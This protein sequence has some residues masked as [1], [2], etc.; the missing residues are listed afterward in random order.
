MSPQGRILRE[1]N[2]MPDRQTGARRFRRGDKDIPR[3]DARAHPIW[4]KGMRP[5]TSEGQ[6]KRA[7]TS[8]GWAPTGELARRMALFRR[9]ISLADSDDAGKFA[10]NDKRPAERGWSLCLTVA[11]KGTVRFKLSETPCA[12]GHAR[13]CGK[14]LGSPGFQEPS[15]RDM[16][17]EGVPSSP[18]S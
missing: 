9:R 6:K 10:F 14:S 8:G 11:L 5:E 15:R 13:L 2:R 18:P 3:R 1:Q 4:G 12:G 7:R 16:F 17:Y